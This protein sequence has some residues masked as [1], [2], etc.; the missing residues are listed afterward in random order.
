MGYKHDYDRALTRLIIIVT[1]LNE[2]EELS[3]SKLAEEF[4]VS[5]R[6]IQRDFNEK[7]ITLYPIEKSGRRWKMR[8]GFKI[9]KIKDIEDVIVLD[10]IEKMSESIGG[11]FYTKAKKMLSKIKNDDFNPIYTKLD[12]EDISNKLHEITILENAI[13]SQLHVECKYKLEDYSVSLELKP[14][15]IANY[16]G[17]WYLIALDARND[18]LKKYYLKN[19]FQSKTLEAEFTKDSKLEELLENSISVWFQSD[20]EP[21]EVKLYANKTVAKYFKRK[22]IS[23]SQHIESTNKDGSIEITLKITHEMEILPLVKYW[24]PNVV[25]L[26]PKWLRDMIDDDLIEYQKFVKTQCEN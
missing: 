4:N 3:V 12:I 21:F 10:I 11:K 6:T 25:V 16:E 18:E 5:E 17:F 9:E 13:K 14:L 24:I 2:G 26:E 1:R 23:K 20:K 15:K 7:L 19:I 8:D 22:P